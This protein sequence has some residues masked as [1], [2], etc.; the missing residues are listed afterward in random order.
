MTVIKPPD[1]YVEPTPLSAHR[2][3]LEIVRNAPDYQFASAL[4]ARIEALEAALL[5]F[6]CNGMSFAQARMN[7]DAEGK[8][9]FPAGGTWCTVTSG[10]AFAKNETIFYNAIDVYGRARMQEYTLKLLQEA[11][12]AQDALNEKNQQNASTH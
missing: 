3:I 10:T 7:L 1:S 12:A 5:P 9:E 6:C 2:T 4:V 11:K 8:P